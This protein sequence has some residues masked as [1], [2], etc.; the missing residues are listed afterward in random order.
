MPF[1][2]KE[3]VPHSPTLVQGP[4][5]RGLGKRPC[6]L[7]SITWLLLPFHVSMMPVTQRNLNKQRFLIKAIVGYVSLTAAHNVILWDYRVL[8]AAGGQ[9]LCG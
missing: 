4:A 5:G 9:R 8:C 2:I 3:H 7:L 1:K 6:R